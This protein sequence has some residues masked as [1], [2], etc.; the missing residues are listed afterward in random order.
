MS[1][2][3]LVLKSFFAA[4]Q[5]LSKQDLLLA[6]HDRSD[7]GLFATV[8]EMAFA[9]RCGVTVNLDAL[10]F[11]RWSD[12]VD[13]FKRSNDE[14]LAGRLRERALQA[15]F[16]EEL[17]AVLQIRAADR[18]RVM[19]LLRSFELGESVVCRRT[20]ESK[21][22][23]RVYAQREAD[24]QGK[25]RRPAARLVRDQLPHAA[26]ARQPGMRA[27]GVRPDP[28]RSRILGCRFNWVLK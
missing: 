18:T 24:V 25:A 17:G 8:C 21:G 15:M 9:G 1:I 5:E 6:Y 19:D 14:Q 7:G 22:R 4:I 3:P 11:D 27:G 10:V 20:S 13:G 2:P 16:A 28:G 23:N 26:A 12:D